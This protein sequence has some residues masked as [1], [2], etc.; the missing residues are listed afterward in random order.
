MRECGTCTK[1]CEGSI[2]VDVRGYEILHRGCPF[3]KL[4]KGCGIHSERPAGC[5]QFF[6]GWIKDESIPEHFKPNMSNTIILLP[7]SQPKILGLVPTE[8]TVAAEMLEWAQSYAD[9]HNLTIKIQE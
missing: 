1:C 3:V 7:L 6:C 4:E 8:G 2:S 9:E 5:A